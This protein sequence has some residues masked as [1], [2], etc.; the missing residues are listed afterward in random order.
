MPD[1]LNKYCSG[2]YE[3]YSVSEEM[4]RKLGFFGIV[5]LKNN[6]TNNIEVIKISG[7]NLRA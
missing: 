3:V 2:A 5:L 4:D 6:I 7:N 1:I